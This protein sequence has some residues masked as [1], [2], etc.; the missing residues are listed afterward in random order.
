MLGYRMENSSLKKISGS[1]C[2]IKLFK[3]DH[4]VKYLYSKFYF[5]VSENTKVARFFLKS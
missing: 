4:Y 2:K 1:M 3:V 5:T